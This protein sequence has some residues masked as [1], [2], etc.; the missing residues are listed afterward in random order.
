MVPLDEAEGCSSPSR[1]A[2]PEA[3]PPVD[4]HISLGKNSPETL[5]TGTRNDPELRP[6]FG[7]R[8]PHADAIVVRKVVK[9]E[10]KKKNWGFFGENI[11]HPLWLDAFFFCF[12]WK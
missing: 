8:P 5:V 3:A 7:A 4:P 9:S 11:C 12:G 6:V 1:R 2:H 10:Q